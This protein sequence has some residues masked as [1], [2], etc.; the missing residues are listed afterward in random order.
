MRRPHNTQLLHFYA[1]HHYVVHD[2]AFCVDGC[3]QYAYACIDIICM[4][5][6]YVY[7]YM[8]LCNR[9][10]AAYHYNRS[11]RLLLLWY[12]REG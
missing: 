1:L 4:Y 5:G 12:W 11:T 3:V 2:N 9:I 10:V 7:T 8:H 6:M